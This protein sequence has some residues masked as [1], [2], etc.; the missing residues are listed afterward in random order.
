M[1]TARQLNPTRSKPK[2]SAVSVPAPIGGLNTRDALDAMP[3]TDAIQLDNW[4][5]ATGKCEVR[6]GYVEHSGGMGS[7]NVE[8]LVEYHAGATRKLIAAAN[9]NLY[10]ATSS[11]ASSIGSGFT[12]NRWQTANFN[13]KIHLVNGDDAPSSAWNNI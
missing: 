12:N 4:F 3:P 10:D 6:D 5:P 2:A 8:T 7:G 9:N 11:T 13:G 1:L